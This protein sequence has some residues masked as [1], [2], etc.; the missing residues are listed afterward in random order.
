GKKARSGLSELSV[1]GRCVHGVPPRIRR[2]IHSNITLYGEPA[3]GISKGLV[4]FSSV[5]PLAGSKRQEIQGWSIRSLVV[6]VW[7]CR[8]SASAACAM[9]QARSGWAG[10]T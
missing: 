1:G 9:A 10:G 8:G 7:R 5:G 2:Y 6:A 4:T 3:Q